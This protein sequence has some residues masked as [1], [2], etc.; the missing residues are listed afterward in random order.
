MSIAC[1]PLAAQ[2]PRAE[3]SSGVAEH[4]KRLGRDGDGR[5]TASPAGKAELFKRADVD[6]DGGVKRA[7]A[8]ATAPK[9]VTAPGKRTAGMEGDGAS[10]VF[11]WPVP[12]VPISESECPVR[13]I[14]A[15]AAD[16]RSVRAWWRRP[17]G[18]ASVPAIVFIHGGLTEFPEAA[19]R[20][21]LTANPVITRFLAAGHAVVMATFRTYEKDVQSRGPI[22]D[23]RAVVRAT[24][25]LPGF[26]PRRITLYGGSG[27]GSIALELGG[28]AE[29]RAVVAGEPATLLYTG[30]LTTSDYV[31]RLEMMA[32]PERFFTPELRQRTRTKLATLR[33]PVLILHGDQHDLRK[34]NG[35]IIVPL[36]KEAGVRV[37]YRE[38][39]GY[40]HGFYFGGGA[41]RWGKGAD[42][43]VVVDVVRDV[44]A[45]LAVESARMRID[46]DDT[47]HFA[48]SG[49]PLN[50]GA[51]ERVLAEF[52]SGSGDKQV[53]I[54]AT[55][56]APLEAV[57]QA[58]NLC[59]KT[60]LNRF[61]L[62]SK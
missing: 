42:E 33:A 43:K 11:H 6:H 2:E 29:V 38:Y 10:A 26:D 51:L 45:F 8:Q 61:S 53:L 27:G 46:I 14:E 57:T 49:K 13:T 56:K 4:L 19:L 44:L 23:V 25:R 41:D 32:S 30:M 5:P 50:E 17:Q 22:E 55:E 47:G 3:N 16:G 34:L 37:E 48:V 59:R 36:M 52:A 1:M 28:D 21:H 58:M 9:S 39:P 12:A 35:P 31:P 24:A 54:V 15:E 40:G 7:E 18:D 62:Q 60:G 20:R